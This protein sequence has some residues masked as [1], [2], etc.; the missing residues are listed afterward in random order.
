MRSIIAAV[1]AL[2]MSVAQ[3]QITDT[4]IIHPVEECGAI[5][6]FTVVEVAGKMAGIT[7]PESTQI[8]IAEYVAQDNLSKET[9][10]VLLDFGRAIHD[11]KWTDVIIDFFMDLGGNI[12]QVTIAY[13]IM[14]VEAKGNYRRHYPEQRI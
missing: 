7:T 9:H 6:T 12:K 1:L 2:F 8:A 5:A 13:R 11:P 10:A 3:A 4:H 14:C